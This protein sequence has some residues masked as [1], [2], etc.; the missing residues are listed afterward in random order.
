MG[1][2]AF[3]MYRLRY[4]SQD[5]WRISVDCWLPQMPEVISSRTGDDVKERDALKKYYRGEWNVGRE[6]KKSTW[7]LGTEV[8]CLLFHWSRLLLANSCDRWKWISDFGVSCTFGAKA[9]V[10]LR[11][12]DHTN[13]RGHWWLW[14]LGGHQSSL[15]VSIVDVVFVNLQTVVLASCWSL[16]CQNGLLNA[17]SSSCFIRDFGCAYDFQVFPISCDRNW[18]EKENFPVRLR[19]QMW[20]KGEN[21]ERYW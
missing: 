18:D 7:R 16:C 11:L 10:K 14:V 1:C 21:R 6:R 8:I 5:W 19:L 4:W 15:S 13:T 20:N 2:V 3:E 12:K 9:A 17:D